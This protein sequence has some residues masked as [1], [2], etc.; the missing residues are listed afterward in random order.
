[1]KIVIDTSLD[2]GD[3][4]YR[5]EYYNEKLDTDIEGIGQ[6]EI[7]GFSI[8]KD[9]IWIENNEFGECCARIDDIDSGKQ[10]D[11]GFAYFSSKEKAFQFIEEYRNGKANN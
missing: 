4:I 11:Y 1:M 10:D 7:Y 8:N 5:I 3:Y 9:G 6:V 2:I